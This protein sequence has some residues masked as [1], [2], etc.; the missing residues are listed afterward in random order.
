MR[1]VVHITVKLYENRFFSCEINETASLMIV[2]TNC[3][4]G[5]FAVLRCCF[6][7]VICF[8]KPPKRL[9]FSEIYLFG[10]CL[11]EIY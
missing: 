3:E 10:K 2:K 9:L 6:C 4:H 5:R 8:D 11:R 7:H 1:S